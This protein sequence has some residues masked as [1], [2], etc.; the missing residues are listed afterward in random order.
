MA[1]IEEALRAAHGK[2]RVSAAKAA[3][4]HALLTDLNYHTE[5]ALLD[6]RQLGLHQIVAE[7]ERVAALRNERGSLR[8]LSDDGIPLA[9]KRDQLVA[10]IEQH[11]RGGGR[12]GNPGGDELERLSAEIERLT[13]EYEKARKVKNTKE[14]AYN[15]APFA[16]RDQ[17]YAA[18]LEADKPYQ[19]AKTR[20]DA[21]EEALAFLMMS[22]QERA[23]TAAR[24]AE[25]ARRRLEQLEIEVA[26]VRGIYERLTAKAQ[27]YNEE[28]R[29]HRR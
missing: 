26:S 5:A 9:R 11:K 15:H 25:D 2:M 6:A 17:R 18:L 4:L 28:A 24:D 1:T 20:L 14:W 23:D 13:D 12:T 19:R 3:A 8:G 21:A 10:Q 7:L 27:R 29:A 22:P 16:A